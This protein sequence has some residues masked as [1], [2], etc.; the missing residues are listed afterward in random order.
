M[1]IKAIQCSKC[2]DIIYSRARHDMRWCTCKNCAID[3][4]QTGYTHLVGDNFEW[5]D[6]K[7]DMTLQELHADW[8]TSKDLYGL[9]KFNAKIKTKKQRKTK[10]DTK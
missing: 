2:K 1:K 10:K 5:V 6:L 3:G 4:G 8:N 7:V 9:V